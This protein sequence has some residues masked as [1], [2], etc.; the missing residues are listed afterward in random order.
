MRRICPKCERGNCLHHGIGSKFTNQLFPNTCE[1]C[2][3]TREKMIQLHQRDWI[4][5]CGKDV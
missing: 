1:Y 4:C 5:I 3:P 2:E